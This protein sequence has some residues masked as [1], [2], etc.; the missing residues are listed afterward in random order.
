MQLLKSKLV[1]YTVTASYFALSQPVLGASQDNPV[2]TTQS[3][4]QKQTQA[5]S[6]TA[7]DPKPDSEEQRSTTARSSR[8]C[9]QA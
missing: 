4:E 5:A 1:C 3:P 8:R 2:A 6:T 7:K 9:V